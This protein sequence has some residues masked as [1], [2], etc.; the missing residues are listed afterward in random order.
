MKRILL[1]IAT[2]LLVAG[3]AAR[4]PII[5]YE[6]VEVKVP[7]RVKAPAPVELMVPIEAS[8]PIFISPAD[9]EAS[10]ALSRE[11]EER[12][13]RLLIEHHDR[14]LAWRTWASP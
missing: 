11:G 5:K 2:L 9:P 1:F 13:K 8:P 12:L 14:E 4:E 3:C 7:V 10:S 6:M